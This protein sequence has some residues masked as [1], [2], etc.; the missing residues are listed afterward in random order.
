[1]NAERKVRKAI[2]HVVGNGAWSGREEGERRALDEQSLSGMQQL[3]K[4][5]QLRR[6]GGPVTGWGPPA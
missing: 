2:H 6:V 3:S 5:L 4:D 1:M